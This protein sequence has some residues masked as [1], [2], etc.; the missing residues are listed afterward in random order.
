MTRLEELERRLLQ[1]GAHVRALESEL[2]EARRKNVQLKAQVEAVTESG[3]R[4]VKEATE[5]IDALQQKVEV[6]VDE[7]QAQIGFRFNGTEEELAKV[8]AS[9][10]AFRPQRIG[11]AVV[12]RTAPGG[13]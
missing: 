10:E 4:R 6:M 3:L 13:Q 12:E 11:A 7:W 5:F 2:A 8:R 1:Q 9:V